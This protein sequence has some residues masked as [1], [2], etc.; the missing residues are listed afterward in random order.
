MGGV[1]GVGGLGGVGSE[2]GVGATGAVGGAVFVVSVS[3][4]GGASDTFLAQELN[5]KTAVSRQTKTSHK[6]LFIFLIL[7]SIALEHVPDI[8]ILILPCN[9]GQFNSV[10]IG[11]S[12]R[13]EAISITRKPFRSDTGRDKMHEA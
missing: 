1:G 13:T 11:K 7:P 12:P 5:T 9:P 6:P 3:P 2:G 4:W 10:S 8:S